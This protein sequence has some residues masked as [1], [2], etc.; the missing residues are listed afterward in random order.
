MF[1]L[2]CGTL[3]Y[4][5]ALVES[6]RGS[7]TAMITVIVLGFFLLFMTGVMLF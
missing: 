7:L 2:L 5:F 6:L 4:N 3:A 1:L